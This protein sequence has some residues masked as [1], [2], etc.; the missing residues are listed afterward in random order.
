MT[1][2]DATPLNKIELLLK[3]VSFMLLCIT[4][5]ETTHKHHTT[6]QA[7]NTSSILYVF[8]SIM[9]VIIKGGLEITKGHR[10]L[11][12]ASFEKLSKISK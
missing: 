1:V 6:R 3:I 2:A 5:T 4:R 10:I 8:F 9:V 7:H 12:K 11:N